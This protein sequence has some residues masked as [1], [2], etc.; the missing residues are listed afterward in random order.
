[1]FLPLMKKALMG[2]YAKIS[3]SLVVIRY[4][5]LPIVCFSQWAE[6]FKVEQNNVSRPTGVILRL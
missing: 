4:S 2:A 1:M 5:A 3:L 6:S